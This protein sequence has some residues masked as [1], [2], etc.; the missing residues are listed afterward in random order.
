MTRKV[1][2]KEKT[3]VFTGS[4]ARNPAT[5]EDIPIWVADYVLMEYG[6]GAIM[7]V[8]AHDE[9]DFA[10][11]TKYGLPIVKVVDPADADA[12]L[13]VI[14]WDGTL[15]NSGRFDGQSCR[16]AVEAITKWV[17]EHGHGKGQTQ[18]RLHDWCI[19]RQRYWGPPIPIIYCDACGIVPVP[20]EDLP[21]VR[22]T[23]QTPFWIRRGTSSGI[24]P[25]TSPTGRS[26]RN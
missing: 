9:R 2:D 1:G 19:S 26:I 14:T 25:A 24:R 18:Y 20:D 3:G 17:E 4:F 12:K 6:T 7:A 23:F 11:A 13:P 8:P 22:Q 16:A 21:N 5:G 15:V 10:F